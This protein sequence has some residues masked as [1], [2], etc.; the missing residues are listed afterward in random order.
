MDLMRVLVIEDDRR[1][2]SFIQKGLEEDGFAVDVL[3]DGDDAGVQAQVVDYDCVA[4][5]AGAVGIPG[6]ARHQIPES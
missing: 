5:A 3:H 1:V 2:A 4:D 6:A